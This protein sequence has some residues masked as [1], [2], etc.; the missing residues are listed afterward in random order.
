M[1]KMISA[2]ERENQKIIL[3]RR[4]NDDGDGDDDDDVLY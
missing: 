1:V 3:Q 4:I 2:R